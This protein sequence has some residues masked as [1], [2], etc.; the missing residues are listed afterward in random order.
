MINMSFKMM[1]VAKAEFFEE[2]AKHTNIATPGQRIT[3]PSFSGAL[4]SWLSY[5]RG[6]AS[7]RPHGLGPYGTPHMD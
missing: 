3:L 7:L 5:G 6:Y 2:L 4:G 1:G